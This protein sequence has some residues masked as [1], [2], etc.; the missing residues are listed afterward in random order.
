MIMTKYKVMAKEKHDKRFHC[1]GN[2][3]EA[4]H[5]D[6][7]AESLAN[8]LWTKEV[9]IIV[10]DDNGIENEITYKAA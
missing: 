10:K 5:A 3:T 4:Y 2:H 9:K 1:Y 8:S 7:N 6:K